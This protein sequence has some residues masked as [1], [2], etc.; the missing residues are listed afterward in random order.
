MINKHTKNQY[1]KRLTLAVFV[2]CH[3]L[4]AFSVENQNAAMRNVIKSE[5][6]RSS[7]WHRY[8]LFEHCHEKSQESEKQQSKPIQSQSQ[9]HLAVNTISGASHNSGFGK[10]SVKDMLRKRVYQ[11]MHEQ[12]N[13]DIQSYTRLQASEYLRFE[14]EP[15]FSYRGEF[16]SLTLK[17]I[18]F[19]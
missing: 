13:M 12:L 7:L 3:A 4:Q 11:F 8:S 15:E 5:S 2:M 19:E 9:A 14:F 18:L 10:K 16:R 1:S 17:A 6:L